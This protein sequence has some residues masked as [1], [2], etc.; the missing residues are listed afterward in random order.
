MNQGWT[1]LA[2][3]AI[4]YYLRARGEC[5]PYLQHIVGKGWPIGSPE[6]TSTN[7]IEPVPHLLESVWIACSRSEWLDFVLMCY[8]VQLS[9]QVNYLKL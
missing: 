3:K 4:Y 2:L 5:S 7:F 8:L 9:G 6:T 1:I